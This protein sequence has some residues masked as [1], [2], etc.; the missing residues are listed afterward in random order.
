MASRYG[1]ADDVAGGSGPTSDAATRAAV[2]AAQ[3]AGVTTAFSEPFVASGPIK[4]VAAAGHLKLRVLD[5]LTG[6]PPGGWPRQATYARLM[7]ANLGAL[8]R[9]LGCP[10]TGIGG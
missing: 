7:E 9:A 1:L 8:N 6:P 2:S 10:N 3:S 5:P 4:A